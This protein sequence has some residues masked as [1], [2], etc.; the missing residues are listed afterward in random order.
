MRDRPKTSAP[1]PKQE[2]CPVPS[3]ASLIAE[4]RLQGA[5]QL[6]RSTMSFLIS[7]IALAGFSPFGQVRAQFMI[8]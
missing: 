4:I 6:A 2:H 3:I 5:P 1:G 8:V 7:P